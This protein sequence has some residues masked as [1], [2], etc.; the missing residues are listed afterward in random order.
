MEYPLEAPALPPSSFLEPAA[1]FNVTELQ[2]LGQRGDSGGQCQEP[3]P[4]E[5]REQD[6]GYRRVADALLSLK[7]W[8]TKSSVERLINGKSPYTGGRPSR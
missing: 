4:E 1:S 7:V 3:A 8:T 2:F 5:Y 6:L